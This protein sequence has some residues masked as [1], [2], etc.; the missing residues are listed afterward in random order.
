MTIGVNHLENCN[1]HFSTKNVLAGKTH[2]EE[3]VGQ[4]QTGA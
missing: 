1:K 4:G 2:H 3:A